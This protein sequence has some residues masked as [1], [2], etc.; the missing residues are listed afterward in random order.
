[1][2]LEPQILIPRVTPGRHFTHILPRILTTQAFKSHDFR[3]PRS[4]STRVLPRTLEIMMQLESY[5]HHWPGTPQNESNGVCIC[6]YVCRVR[7][8]DFCYVKT[9]ETGQTHK[10]PYTSC[11]F[12]GCPDA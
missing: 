4:H 5:W 1:M 8:G 6:V 10:N 11:E 2:I 12:V 9:T 3:T 7:F